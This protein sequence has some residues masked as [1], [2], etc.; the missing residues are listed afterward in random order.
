[1]KFTINKETN[2][3]KAFSESGKCVAVFGVAKD[4]LKAGVLLE[5]REDCK[6]NIVVVQAPDWCITEHGS[7]E[8]AKN[9]LNNFS[10]GL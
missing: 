3:R 9:F 10:N 8:Q 6:Q 4:L 1:M 5:V 2:V 7:I